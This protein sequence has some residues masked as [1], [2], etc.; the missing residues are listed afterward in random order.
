MSTEIKLSKAQ[1]SKI[2][3][4][5]GFLGSLLS[6]IASPLMK[7]IAPLAKNILT[8]LGITAAASTIH[9]GV[10]KEFHGPYCPSSSALQVTTVIISNKEWMAKWKL[11]KNETKEQKW[12]FL[13][14]LLGTL[15]ASLSGNFL[16]GK[17]SIVKR[18]GWGIVRAGYG[19]KGAD[20][21]LKKN[22]FLI[23]PH[24]LTNFKIRKWTQN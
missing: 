23:P 17:G 24:T 22:F 21:G 8:P 1:I 11:F 13:S 14:M 10:Q 7:V 20:Y 12:G 2:T 3:K 15:G 4:S 18:Q 19:A 5:A 6:K 16:S 9:P